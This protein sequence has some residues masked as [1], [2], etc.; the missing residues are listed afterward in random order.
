MVFVHDYT[1]AIVGTF[2]EEKDTD[3]SSAVFTSVSKDS[4]D[5]ASKSLNEAGRLDG[6]LAIKN[7]GGAPGVDYTGDSSDPKF[8]GKIARFGVIEKDI[9]TER[10]ALLATNLYDFY[11]PIS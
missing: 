10:G 9:G 2:D 11:K 8:A 1:G 6:V 7:F 4:T 5:T 3:P